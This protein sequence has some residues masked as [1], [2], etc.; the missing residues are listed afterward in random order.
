MFD[1]FVLSSSSGEGF[2]NVIIESQSCQTPVISTKVGDADLIMKMKKDFLM[3]RIQ[4]NYP[5]DPCYCWIKN[6]PK[7]GKL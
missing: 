4:N 5:K 6:K 3:L 7:I 2:P 1:L